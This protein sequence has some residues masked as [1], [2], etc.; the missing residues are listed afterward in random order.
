[1]WR[2][3]NLLPIKPQTLLLLAVIFCGLLTH[4]VSNESGLPSSELAGDALNSEKTNKTPS[5][6]NVEAKIIR[7]MTGQKYRNLQGVDHT[8]LKNGEI[9]IAIAN[10]YSTSGLLANLELEQIETF[11]YSSKESENALSGGV[12]LLSNGSVALSGYR[13]G[14][15]HIF[16]AD[17]GQEISR[18]GTGTLNIGTMV[19]PLGVLERPNGNILVGDAGNGRIVE[20]EASGEFVQL[21]DFP[22]LG[23]P[24]HLTLASN[25]LIVSDRAA[26]QIHLLNEKTKEVRSIDQF[27]SSDQSVVHLLDGNQG[28]AISENGLIYVVNSNQSTILVGDMAGELIGVIHH[29]DFGWVRHITILPNETIAVTQFNE[30]KS[31]LLIFQN[32][33]TEHKTATH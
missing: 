14:K 1:M 5:S 31:G 20:F 8:L 9:L 13:T 17:D 30:E 32:P 19:H 12:A 10:G 6:L 29:E 33:F 28:V 21:I 23:F 18:F 16:S 2:V 3:L 27:V 15:I 22:E 11:S 4:H 7:A 26:S 24:Y 25:H